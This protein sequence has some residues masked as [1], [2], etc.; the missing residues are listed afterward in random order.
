[1]LNNYN[2]FNNEK[3]DDLTSTFL[4]IKNYHPDIV[5]KFILELI[6]FYELNDFCKD[7]SFLCPN[8]C[9][10]GM[11]SEKDKQLIINH[12]K[13]IETLNKI[14]INDY[15]IKSNVYRTILHEIKHIL[16]HKMINKRDGELCQ[17]FQYEFSNGCSNI[18]PSEVNADIESLLVILKN[19]NKSNIL[20]DKQLTF[21][22]NLIYSYYEPQ[23]IVKN[24]CQN[25]NIQILNI[26][27]MNKFLYGLDDEFIKVKK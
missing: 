27:R 3:V 11:Y 21:S 19:Y 22:L 12:K 7:I 25:N 9:Y 23:C 13:I 5:E 6:N 26:D 18:L 1:M 16:Q 10:L 17:L 4:E 2:L 15:F 14:S 24:F 8:S 20:Y